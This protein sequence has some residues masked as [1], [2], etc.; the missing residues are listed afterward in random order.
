MRSQLVRLELAVRSQV[1]Q[2]VGLERVVRSHVNS[3]LC[4]PSLLED[5]LE[6]YS[7][8]WGVWGGTARHIFQDK[9]TAKRRNMSRRRV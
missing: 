5:A 7:E 9:P 6:A 2:P 4:V 3:Q 8:I 1:S